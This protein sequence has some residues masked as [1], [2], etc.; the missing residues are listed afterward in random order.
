MK[1]KNIATGVVSEFSDTFPRTSDP[2]AEWLL[3]E[4]YEF[5]IEAALPSYAV[6]QTYADLRAAA[7]MPIQEQLDMQYWDGINGTSLWLD[8]ITEIKLMYPKPVI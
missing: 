4:G 1:I 3:S 2:N 6:A 7:Y 5:Y 8:Y